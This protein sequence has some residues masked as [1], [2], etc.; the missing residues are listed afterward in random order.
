MLREVWT[1]AHCLGNHFECAAQNSVVQ[2]LAVQRNFKQKLET[3]RSTKATG[4]A[5]RHCLN[6]ERSLV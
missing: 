6:E 4:I 2:L 1:G 5:T 3:F